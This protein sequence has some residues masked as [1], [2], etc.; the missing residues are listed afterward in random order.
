MSMVWIK[1]G[2]NSKRLIDEKYLKDTDE[3]V[4][5]EDTKKFEVPMGSRSNRVYDDATRYYASIQTG[6]NIRTSAD[7]RQYCK[8]NNS[9]IVEK[10]DHVDK[11]VKNVSEDQQRKAYDAR[12]AGKVPF[13]S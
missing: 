3:V 11:Q 4:E 1:T 2:I 13:A 5:V 6:R 7:M 10:G 9:R 8:D 12:K